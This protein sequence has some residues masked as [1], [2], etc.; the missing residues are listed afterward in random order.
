LK[1]FKILLKIP[2][3]WVFVITYLIGVLLQIIFPFRIQSAK[4]INLILIA[5]FVLFATGA[6]FAAWSLIIFR[7][8]RTTT[9][10]GQQSAKLVKN[11]PYSFTRNPMYVSLTLAYLGETG[12]LNQIWPV[13]VLPLVLAYV[14]WI[15]IPI[16]EDLLRKDF[17]FEYENYCNRVRRWF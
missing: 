1:P 10:P 2:V 3:P 5:G 12:F 7:R 16:E 4:A 15:V 13:L 9:T 14:N 6:F 8:A 17:K 11:G